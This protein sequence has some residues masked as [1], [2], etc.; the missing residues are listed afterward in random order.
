MSEYIDNGATLGWLVDPIDKRVYVFRPGEPLQC[1][2]HPSRLEGDPTLPGFVLELD[3]ILVAV[4]AV[5][6]IVEETLSTWW[7]ERPEHVLE[8][9]PERQKRAVVS[10][11]SVELE[12]HG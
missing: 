3:E 11:R 10:R 5:L 2:E 9:E 8:A 1:L 6:Q 4:R 7:R 12:A